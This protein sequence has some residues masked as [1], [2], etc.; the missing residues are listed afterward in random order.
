M[1]IGTGGTSWKADIPIKPDIIES[2][3]KIHDINN[4]TDKAL[5]LMLYIMRKQMFLDWNKRTAILCANRILI[6]NGAGLV[7]I[8][9]EHIKEFK[10]KLINFYET[11]KMD[12]IKN[13]LFEKCIDGII[14]SKP[15]ADEILEQQ[16]NSEFFQRYKK[17]Q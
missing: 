2:I 13:F 10:N 4:A 1:P 15:T 3:D 7:N 14:M 5:T 12:E 17:R 16:K 9:V 6:E 11:N 8:Q